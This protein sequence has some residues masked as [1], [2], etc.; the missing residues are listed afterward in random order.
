MLRIGLNSTPTIMKFSTQ[1]ADTA[2]NDIATVLHRSLMVG[3]NVLWLTSGG[4]AIPAQV[5]IM[6]ELAGLLDE[7]LNNLLILPVDERYGPPNHADS[8]TA[9]MRAA[10]FAPGSAT[11]HDVLADDLPL[12]ETIIRYQELAKQAFDKAD[13]V[14]ATLGIGSDG[15]T[16][17]VL[18][19]SP[20]VSDETS[21][22]VSYQWADYARLTLG[23]QLLRR[24]DHAFVL[25][26]GEGKHDAIKR[27]RAHEE[28]LRTLPAVFLYDLPQVTVYN[29]YII[30]EG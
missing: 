24:I 3:E 7:Q 15:H 8:N 13:L 10:G 6:R 26:Y 19:D 12:D 16:A 4:S 25:A 9:Q 27:L 17:G 23:L 1:P 22:A 5:A 14:I 21:F 2:S 18:P 11:W 30:A 29:D 20:A 28:S